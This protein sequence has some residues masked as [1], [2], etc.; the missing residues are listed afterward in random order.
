MTIA[1]DYSRANREPGKGV[2]WVAPMRKKYQA[3]SRRR[4]L[5][6]GQQSSIGF[7]TR[8]VDH[9]RVE[10]PERRRAE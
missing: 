5:D 8:A 9:V 10:A 6:V 3:R 2:G 4:D 7:G 1:K